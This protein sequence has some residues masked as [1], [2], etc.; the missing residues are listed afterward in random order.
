MKTRQTLI[1][2]V[3]Y[4]VLIVIALIMI[5][6]FLWAFTA[7]FKTSVQIF[8]GNPFDLIPKPFTLDNYV[9]AWTVLPFYRFVLNSLMLSI[10]VPACI[11]VLASLAAYSFARLN[12]KGRDFVF[13]CLLGVMMMPGHIT[14]IPNYSLMRM[15]GWIND[16]RALIVPMIFQ[17]SLVFNIFFMR[18]YFL[19]I[20]KEMDEAAIIDGCSRF[21][22]WWRVIM[23]NARPALA[24]IAI[25]SFVSEWNTFLWPVIVIND[26]LK[27]PIQV[28]VSY[29]KANVN[30]WGVLM[31]ATTMAIVPL[32]I[33]FGVF[34][35]HF[36]K[37]M[38][39][40]GLSGK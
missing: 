18:Q 1:H 13:L 36:I 27:M 10:I 21:G 12:F 23:P 22:V 2:T 39:T 37:S 11:I 14:L 34:Q 19:A 6:P 16:Y 38:L 9:R 24:T 28:G 33:V 26:Y 20:P 30:D 29:F 25:L 15:L 17:G 31:A 4:A 40:S 5:Y 35:K 3:L 7:S 32:I 8:N